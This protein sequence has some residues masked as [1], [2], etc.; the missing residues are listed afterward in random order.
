MQ[1][2]DT[3]EKEL[4]KYIAN[5]LVTEQKFSESIPAEFD[6][7]FCINPKQV[8][9]FI[10]AT[11]ADAWEMLQKKGECLEPAKLTTNKSLTLFSNKLHKAQ[12]MRVLF[13][14]PNVNRNP[15]LDHH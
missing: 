14:N 12:S 11:Q 10:K 2:T 9:S 4:Q 7:E 1:F 15:I 6:R 5:Y 3:S 13:L 8:L